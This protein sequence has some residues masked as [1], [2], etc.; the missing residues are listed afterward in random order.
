M[1]SN[2]AVEGV[3]GGPTYSDVHC[4]QLNLYTTEARICFGSLSLK[5]KGTNF[6]RVSH[7][8]FEINITEIFPKK[9]G[10]FIT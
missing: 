9:V 6:E 7:N 10:E 1:L 2:S 4:T 5:K 3:R 8:Y